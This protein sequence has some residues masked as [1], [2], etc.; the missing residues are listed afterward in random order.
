MLAN[1]PSGRKKPNCVIFKGLL[2]VA[3][4]LAAGDELTVSYGPHYRR[5]CYTPSP[6]CLRKCRYPALDKFMPRAR[7]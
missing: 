1:E 2:V 6:C 7:K 5:L 3:T 4:A